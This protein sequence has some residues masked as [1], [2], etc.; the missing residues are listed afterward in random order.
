MREVHDRLGIHTGRGARSASGGRPSTSRRWREAA[1]RH[2]VARPGDPA[3]A[4]PARLDPDPQVG[5]ARQRRQNLDLFGLQALRGRGRRHH[6]SLGRA[7][8]RLFGA[9]GHPRGDVSP[10][11]PYLRVD[12]ARLRANVARVADQAA[13]AG[14]SLRPHAKTHSSARRSR[15][16]SSRRARSG[17]PSR[18]SAGG[19]LRR[20]G[21]RGPLH[22]LPL[23]LTD[24]AITTPAR[25]L[26]PRRPRDRR[27]LDGSATRAGTLLEG[28][29]SRSSSGRQRP[30]PQ[31]RGARAAGTVAAAAAEAGRLSAACSRS[32]S[33][34]APGAGTDAAAESARP[35]V[36]GRVLPDRRARGRTSSVAARRRRS[37][38]ASP[39]RAPVRS[40]SCGRRLRLR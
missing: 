1:R 22:R 10:A 23:W 14:V 5:H 6:R 16:S 24:D 27:R 31:R 34:Y 32:R 29:A 38:P 21:R 2:A 8:G 4:G 17:S 20:A 33:S 7:D 35:A 25:P 30:A 12:T 19:G 3:L 15:G 26:R 28:R 11:T 18:R 37:P 13:T 36:G 9:A 40:P 39:T